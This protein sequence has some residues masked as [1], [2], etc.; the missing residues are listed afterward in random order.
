MNLKIEQRDTVAPL[1]DD[2]TDVVA[3]LLMGF[4]EEL[5]F[6]TLCHCWKWRSGTEYNPPP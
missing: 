6:P 3:A 5:N 2:G 1:S 4:K